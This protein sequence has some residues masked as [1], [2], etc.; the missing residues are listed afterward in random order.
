[1]TPS[2]K[3]LPIVENWDCHNCGL[4]C[5]GTTIRLDER[6][7]A[8]LREQD[9]ENHPD[10]CGVKTITRERWLGGRPVLAKQ[11]DGSCVFLSDQGRCRIHDLHGGSAKPAVCRMFPFQLVPLD[12]F[13]YVTSRRSCP[14]AAADEGRPLEEQ[15]SALRKSGL[16]ARFAAPHTAPPAVVRGVRKAWP[17][18]LAAADALAKL[19]TNDRLPLV[20]RLIDGLQFCTLLEECK[21]KRISDG[22]WKGLI[23]L[24]ES[25]ASEGSSAF[26]RDRKPPSSATAFLFRQT[27]VHYIRSHPGFPVAQSWRSDLKLVW[28]S[29]KFA[30]GRGNVPAIHPEFPAATF[31]QLERPLGPLT[32]EVALPLNRY[33]ETHVTSKQYA[34][35]GR[36][37]SLVESFRTLALT[38]PMAL[39]LLRLASGQDAPTV[40]DMLD[41]VTALERGYGM[42]SL[43]RGATAMANTQQ[44]ERLVAWH[45]R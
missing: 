1:M 18:F 41:I 28:L 43:S 24:L 11:A 30:R 15:L 36:R 22:D 2:I 9:W 13:A 26:F 7:L 19:L 23:Q 35:V 32:D 6:D 20:R 8:L 12:R 34:V 5:R 25:S 17:E 14:S 44:L 38:Y 10:F 16:L 4:C 31:A 27:A 37:K 33:I 40:K 39:W 3:T 42:S 29:A 21:L 45:A